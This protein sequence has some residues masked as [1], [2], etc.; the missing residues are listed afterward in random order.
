ML[1]ILRTDDIHTSFPPNNTASITHDLDRGANLHS[2]D[3][4]WCLRKRRLVM[5]DVGMMSREGEGCGAHARDQWSTRCKKSSKH[6]ASCRGRRRV[7]GI[8]MCTVLVANFRLGRYADRHVT[9]HNA[10]RAEFS[11]ELCRARKS[12]PLHHT[13]YTHRFPSLGR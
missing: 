7:A 11:P 3:L 4:R 2:P 8:W 9:S 1:G 6:C 13:L 5:G 12:L 10:R